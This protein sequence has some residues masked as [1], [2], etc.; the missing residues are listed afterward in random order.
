MPDKKLTTDNVTVS[1][2]TIEVKVMKIGNRQ[3]TLAV[4][5]QLPE[6]PIIYPDTGELCGIPWG[7]VN[8]HVDCEAIK[9][10]HLHVV[11]Q[12]GSELRRAIACPPG[13]N[14]PNTSGELSTYAKLDNK[15]SEYCSAYVALLI[16]NG[17]IPE[18]WKETVPEHPHLADFFT[19][20]LAGEQ[21]RHWIHPDVRHAW[22]KDHIGTLHTREHELRKYISQA[23]LPLDDEAIAQVLL[24]AY[25]KLKALTVAWQQS[26]AQLE[27]LDQLFIAV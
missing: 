13:Y 14:L 9:F 24:P 23:R 21:I 1:T 19:L 15:V 11:W 22:Y 8:Y 12:K 17:W 20:T 18:S 5:R 25:H 7:R 4:F 16:L 3:V 27:Q 26:Y 10:S 6:E 2:A